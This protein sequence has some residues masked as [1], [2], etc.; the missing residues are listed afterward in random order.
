MQ[1]DIDKIKEEIKDML[2][3]APIDSEDEPQSIGDPNKI[4][5]EEENEDDE[6][7]ENDA[8]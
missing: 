8:N 6:P 1:K 7:E 4:F 2:L 5:M 3:N